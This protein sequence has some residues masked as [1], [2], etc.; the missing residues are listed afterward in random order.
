[1]SGGP[2]NIGQLVWVR[3]NYKSGIGSRSSDCTDSSLSR[4][5][6]DM[7]LL[8]RNRRLHCT[9]AETGRRSHCIHHAMANGHSEPLAPFEDQP[10]AIIQGT[11]VHAHERNSC[12]PINSRQV[13][14]SDD[15]KTLN[16]DQTMPRAVNQHRIGFQL[17]MACM[18]GTT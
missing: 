13:A 11:S 5:L 9:Q 10:R 1:M 14:M 6:T 3:G 17:D 7:M 8:Y 4:G 12:R 18:C 16:L 2:L 15:F